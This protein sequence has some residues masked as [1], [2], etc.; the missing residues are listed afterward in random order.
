MQ[1]EKL[2][3]VGLGSLGS[4]LCEKLCKLRKLREITLI[5]YDIVERKNLETSNFK[6]SDVGLLKVD[7]M[8]KLVKATSK[9]I[10]VRKIPEK[11][12]EGQTK[13]PKADL[14]LDTRDFNYDRGKLIDARLF[15]SLPYLVVDCRKNV[16][17]HRKYEGKYP[18]SITREDIVDASNHAYSLI[19]RGYLDHL[20][21]RQS[22]YTI[23]IDKITKDFLESSHTSYDFACDID[24][25]RISNIVA[26]IPAVLEMN[27]QTEVV[28]YLGSKK[29]PVISRKLPQN[30]LRTPNDVSSC[31]LSMLKGLPDFRNYFVVVSKKDFC[32]ELI[33]ETASA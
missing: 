24:E 14:V 1:I 10:R 6:Q 20:L 5:D 3:L 13:I 18:L 16:T 21:R 23:E 4:F 29:D 7:A 32:I 27:N 28:V 15:L 2:V 30:F 11:F 19:A 31:F 33:P 8:A 12:V 9:E 26:N 17:Y 25:S 22:V